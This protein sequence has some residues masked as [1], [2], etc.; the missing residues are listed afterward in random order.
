MKASTFLSTA[1]LAL[2]LAAGTAA[3]V[4]AANINPKDFST[5]ID[6]PFFPLV[7]NTTFVYVGTKDGSPERDEFQVTDQTKVILGVHCRQVRD[8]GYI[9][10]VLAEDTLDWFAQDKNGNVFYFGED[11]KELDENGNVI[12]TEGSW[13][14]GVNGAL[15]GIVME[16]NPHVG[17]TY[18]Q[19]FAAPVAEDMATVLALHKT[20]NVPFG[21]FSNCLETEEFS[22]LEPGAIEHKFYARGVGF[23]QSVA[24]RG[25]RER[26]ELVTILQTQ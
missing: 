22:P 25:G 17:D 21:S 20:V 24:L 19:E 5:T 26:L 15:P 6:N 4:R 14:A 11:T 18:Q 12:S 7:P 2:T 10:G 8:R 13:Q 3:T 9:N 16:A 1:L 23:V